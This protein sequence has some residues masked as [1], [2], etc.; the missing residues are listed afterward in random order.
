MIETKINVKGMV[1]E[2]CER[3]VEN[4]LNDI[5]GVLEVKADH[6]TGEVIIKSNEEIS[7]SIIRERIE[8]LDFELEE[9]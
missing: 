9:N 6:A 3:R 2:G 4:S 7:K 5:D 8:D 1:C